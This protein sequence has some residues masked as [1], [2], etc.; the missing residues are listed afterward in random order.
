MPTSV[1]REVLAEILEAELA[2]ARRMLEVLQLER[3]ALARRDIPAMEQAAAEK[4]RL[5][6]LLDS[7]CARQDTLLREVGI[8]PRSPEHIGHGL[9]RAGLSGLS[10]TWQA[11]RATLI[12]CRQQNLVNGGTVETMRRFARDALA[13]LRGL[14]TGT[15]VYGRTGETRQAEGGNPLAT[16]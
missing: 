8:D 12:E 10:P 6:E 16:A 14:P 11:L 1:P 9:E 3:D 7:L 15:L 13:L 4:E 5:I 2:R